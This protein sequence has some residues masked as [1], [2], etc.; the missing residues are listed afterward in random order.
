MKGYRNFD[1][2][3]AYKACLRAAEYDTTGIKCP[4]L[5][6]PHLMPKAKYYKNAIGYIPCDRENESVAK[7][8]EYAYDD[9]CISIFAEAMSDFE[10]KAKYERFA[11]AYGFIST[12]QSASCV[13][14]TQKVNGVLHS[15]RV[16]LLTAAMIIVKE[17]LG[18][19]L[20][21]CRM[22]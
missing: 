16:H 9:W 14:W 17:Q 11:K 2:K 13:D 10:S 7:A 19:G 1:A 22:M 5:V 12:N 3:E 4:D 18:N 20:G 15:I 8:L 21:L 6:L